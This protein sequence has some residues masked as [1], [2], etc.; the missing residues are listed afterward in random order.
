MYCMFD[1][2]LHGKRSVSMHAALACVDPASVV[3][4]MFGA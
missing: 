1:R 2:G 3:Q 4:A